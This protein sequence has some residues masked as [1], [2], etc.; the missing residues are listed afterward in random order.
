MAWRID[1]R[2]LT[3]PTAARL[4]AVKGRGTCPETAAIASRRKRGGSMLTANAAELSRQPAG[5]L[6]GWATQAE[7]TGCVGA[8]QGGEVAIALLNSVPL[9]SGVRHRLWHP[10]LARSGYVDLGPENRLE[11]I[12]PVL[13]ES[14]AAAPVS[15]D[16]MT[17]T[18]SA[19]GL[20]VEM[21]SAPALLGVETSWYAVRPEGVEPMGA[22]PRQPLFAGVHARFWRL[23]YKADQSSAVVAANSREELEAA[24]GVLTTGNGVCSPCIAVPRAVAVNP[25]LAVMV[26]GAEVR[27]PVGSN[28]RRLIREAG[29]KP[30]D[31][32]AK[33][34]MVKPYRG[35]KI[36]V[37]YDGTKPDVLD[38]VLEGNEEIR[39]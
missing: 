11:V 26:N 36:L 9:D 4:V 5:W 25:F 19:R 1:G 31:V 18:E 35:R 14:T 38:L 10:V 23:V 17:V 37:K 27:V 16:A 39:W 32:V 2:V 22:P 33:L 30:E 15:P 13:R 7:Q 21:K 28:L 12:V 8:G 29:M 24:T 34:T 3:P 6:M 20:T